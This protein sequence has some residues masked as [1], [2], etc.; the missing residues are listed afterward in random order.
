MKASLAFVSGALLAALLSVAALLAS[1]NSSDVQVRTIPWRTQAGRLQRAIPLGQGFRCTFDGLHSID[2]ALVA[3]GNAQGAKLELVLRAEGPEGPV[4][5]RSMAHSLPAQSGWGVFNFKPLADSAGRALWWQLEWPGEA[6]QSVH[7]PWIRYHGQVGINMAWGNT[8]VRG[9][10]LEGRLADAPAG[11]T[12]PGA[13]SRVPHPYLCAVAFA[14]ENLRPA[15]GPVRLELWGPGQDPAS[16]PALRTATLEDE[17]EVHGGYAFFAF[18]PIAQSRWSDITYRLT[19]NDGAKLVGTE[20]A[21][22]R[23]TWHGKRLSDPALLGHSRGARIHTDR[24]LIF[25]AHS[26]PGPRQR[27]E[28]ILERGGWRL[29]LGALCWIIAA[30]LLFRALFG[31]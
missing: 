2:V 8:I 1:A 14:A 28:Q 13:Y 4:L 3:L 6:R 11:Q 9:P 20:G 27:L 16:D 25:R 24:S 19:L 10:Q 29:L 30:G 22:S 15:V 17:D 7:S 23:L 12:A 26:A 5:R 21:P 18:E 31:R